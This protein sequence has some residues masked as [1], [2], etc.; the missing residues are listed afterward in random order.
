MFNKIRIALSEIEKRE[1]FPARMH[2]TVAFFDLLMFSIPFYTA[3]Q[4]LKTIQVWDDSVEWIQGLNRYELVLDGNKPKFEVI[5]N[6]NVI[7]TNPVYDRWR[8]VVLVKIPDDLLGLTLSAIPTNIDMTVVKIILLGTQ[9]YYNVFEN[10][11][12]PA[13]IHNKVILCNWD[14]IREKLNNYGY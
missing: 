10:L 4:V 11:V 9:S 14:H 5:P 6:K 2:H 12:S 3:L 1:G 7:W 8:R 13:G